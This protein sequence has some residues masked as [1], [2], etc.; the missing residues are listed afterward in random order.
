MPFAEFTNAEQVALRAVAVL[1]T[2]NQLLTQA[3]LAAQLQAANASWTA[4]YQVVELA[5]DASGNAN[6]VRT[7]KINF[8][9]L[10]PYNSASSDTFAGI[11]EANAF[12]DGDVIYFSVKENRLIDVELPNASLKMWAAGNYLKMVRVYGVW[13]VEV[14]APWNQAERSATVENIQLLAA[15]TEFLSTTTK[16]VITAKGAGTP[17][18]AV[19]E[20][21]AIATTGDRIELYVDGILIAIGVD[22]TS[23]DAMGADLANYMNTIPDPPFTASYN[24]PTNELTISDARNLGAT[25]NSFLLS[26]IELNGA[27]GTVIS[28]F[29]GGVDG[30]DSNVTIDTIN[31]LT[32][33]KTLEVHNGMSANNVVLTNV[34]SNLVGTV[35]PLTISPNN[36]AIVSCIVAGTGRVR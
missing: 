14:A 20:I 25:A 23:I 4:N 7:A 2:T 18:S 10:A 5:L 32:E 22:D 13:Q 27:A 33:G 17:A 1:Y 15:D 11:V 19:Y 8:I 31:G 36:F 29:A 3:Q 24:A 34:G 12:S 16:V 30:A 28:Q 21:T 9:R 6:V 26:S 35:L